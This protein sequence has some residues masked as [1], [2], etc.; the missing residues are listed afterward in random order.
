TAAI[1]DRRRLGIDAR[2]GERRGRRLRREQLQGLG[3]AQRS[4]GH[5]DAGGDPTRTTI[6][7]A[8]AGVR[9]GTE[10]IDDS[11]VRLIDRGEHRR[12][13]DEQLR[14]GPRSEGLWRIPFVALADRP[15]LALP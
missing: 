15:A 7:R 12:R 3:I 5:V 11:R 2:R 9:L 13:I 10:G 4:G 1:E 8:L 6:A 14:A